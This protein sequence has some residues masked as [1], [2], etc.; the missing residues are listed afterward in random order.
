MS[1]E[2]KEV[3]KPIKITIVGGMV[4]SPEAAKI[5]RSYKS[6]LKK[7]RGHFTASDDAS[8]ALLASLIDDRNKC[9]LELIEYGSRVIESD[10]REGVTRKAHPAATEKKDL[11]IQIRQTL[12]ELGLT[13]KS[14]KQMAIEAAQKQENSIT[15]MMEELGD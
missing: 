6:L 7:E 13:P 8:V 1:E 4:L 15:K 5:Y 14:K 12:I 9:E 11:N 2:V 3:K 10:S